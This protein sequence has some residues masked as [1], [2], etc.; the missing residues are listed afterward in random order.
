MH[1]N[2]RIQPK[3]QNAYCFLLLADVAAVSYVAYMESDKPQN[4]AL[5][6]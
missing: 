3:E 1:V 6:K 5:S 4:D 2:F